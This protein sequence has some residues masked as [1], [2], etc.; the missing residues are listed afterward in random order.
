MV[1]FVADEDSF[2]GSAHAMLIIVLFE[3]FEAREDGGVF[4]WLRLFGSEGVVGEGVEAD[5][6]GLV[7]V[8]GFG[9]ERWV[10]GLQCS[11]RYGRH[12]G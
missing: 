5:G 10:G 6:F 3:A 7:A 9:E 8:E 2:A 11:S 12:S 1:V 4:F